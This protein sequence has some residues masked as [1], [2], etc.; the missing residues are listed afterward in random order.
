MQSFERVCLASNFDVLLFETNHGGRR[1][2]WLGPTNL[3]KKIP[4]TDQKEINGVH[5]KRI[6]HRQMETVNR[7]D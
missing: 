6:G 1:V 5:V 7:N 4:F 2:S 3:G